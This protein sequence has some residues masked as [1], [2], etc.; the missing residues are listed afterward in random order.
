MPS[1]AA[2]PV[3]DGDTPLDL[4]G[5]RDLV[6]HRGQVRKERERERGRDR[7][8][9]PRRAACLSLSTPSAPPLFSFFSKVHSVAWSCTGHRLASAAED[10]T[11]KV[12]AIDHAAAPAK[13]P[14]RPLLDLRAPPPASGA[15][16]GVSGAKAGSSTGAGQAGTPGAPATTTPTP[17]T[18][19]TP[20]RP[21]GA[22]LARVAWDPSHRDRLAAVGDATPLRLWD[23]RGGVVKAS[24]PTGVPDGAFNISLAWCGAAGGGGGRATTVAVGNDADGVSL[25]DLAA[26]PGTLPFLTLPRPG[27]EVNELAFTPDGRLLARA[28]GDGS[29]E[30]VAW[31]EGGRVVAALRG[32][33]STV[34]AVAPHPTRPI[35]AS[36]GADG[37]AAVW[38]LRMLAPLA[39]STAL[40]YPVKSVAF[41]GPG[42]SLLASGGDQAALAID[43]WEGGGAVPPF[44]VSLRAPVSQLAW[45]PAASPPA[46][47]AFTGPVYP[48]PGRD[49]LGAVGILAPP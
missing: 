45:C 1:L 25:L 31:R 9:R 19:T 14:E 32:H 41:G 43:A 24:L 20:A 3:G 27:H 18:T 7:P 29:V 34:F 33:T 30:L 36:G 15:G 2:V 21:R 22:R 6:A 28:A 23:A 35:L 46:V 39:V 4:F 8:P 47:L 10:G 12:W 5:A 48:G 40:D 37:A 16:G 44:V 17:A 42:G 38:D 49:E 26:P 13:G 11:I